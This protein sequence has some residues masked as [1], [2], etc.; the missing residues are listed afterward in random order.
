MKRLS[1]I[2][3]SLVLFFATQS[4]QS[5][6]TALG[7]DLAPVLTLTGPI[8]STNQI[9]Y[10]TDLGQANGWT[11]LTN[12]VLSQ[13][14]YIFA[15]IS[16]IGQPRRFYRI[17]GLS[18]PGNPDSQ[19]LVWIPAG[20]FIMGS[21]TNEVGRFDNEGPQTQVTFTYGFY[22][23]KYEVTQ[24]KYLSLIESN[25]SHFTAANGYTDDLNLPVDGVSWDN[26]TN[27]CTKLTQQEQTAGRLPS[28]MVYRLPTEAEWEYA[29]RAGTTSPFYF[30]NPANPYAVTNYAWYQN[31]SGGQTHDV[32][33]KIPNNWGLYDM[34]GNVWEWCSGAYGT[35]YPGGSVTNYYVPP[36]DSS[37]LTVI[38]GGSFNDGNNLLRSASRYYYWET[39]YADAWGFRVVLA[40]PLP[41]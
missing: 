13:S 12:I 16:A 4:A 3:C 31:N 8:G 25:P 29:C 19:N 33:Q 21:P 36:T 39:R 17:N 11:N 34:C 30:G 7:I 23:G 2:T 6:Q 14:T 38:R 35:N 41:Q 9:Q 26:A 15:D 37:S 10:T 1:F 32:G 22:M 28:G 27:Y 24:G 40:P 5:A 18:Q 20:T